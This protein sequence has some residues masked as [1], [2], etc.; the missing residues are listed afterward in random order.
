MVEGLSALWKSYE[1][2]ALK[3]VRDGNDAA[4]A[5]HF[6]D[7]ATLEG[8]AALG[9]GSP[10]DRLAMAIAMIEADAGPC[11]AGIILRRVM[12]DLTGP[13]GASVS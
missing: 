4:A 11:Q 2:K 6:S 5:L 1:S 3:A 10:L 9:K 13:G 8:E 12:D 7:M